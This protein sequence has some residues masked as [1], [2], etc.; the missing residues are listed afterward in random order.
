MESNYIKKVLSHLKNKATKR[1]LEAELAD[2][3]ALHKEQYAEIGYE[4]ARAFSLAEGKMG[5]ADVAGEQLA[6]LECEQKRRCRLLLGLAVLSLL[7]TVLIPIASGADSTLLISS[8]YFIC[9]LWNLIN[10][11]LGLRYK[12]YAN[13]LL[14]GGSALI[15]LCY[16][17]GFWG[18]WIVDFFTSRQQYKEFFGDFQPELPITEPVEYAMCVLAALLMLTGL[19]TTFCFRRGS[20]SK[21]NKTAGHIS[22]C[23]L[24]AFILLLSAIL[25]FNAVCIAAYPRR[26]QQE[27][28]AELQQFDKV[29]ADNLDDILQGDFTAVT[30]LESE[31]LDVVVRSA[32][33]SSKAFIL[34]SN[35]T[36]YITGKTIPYNTEEA[37]AVQLQQAQQKDF[38]LQDITIPY[39]YYIEVN[40]DG[41]ANIY[42][43]FEINDSD[44]AKTGDNESQRY[45]AFEWDDATLRV[46][47]INE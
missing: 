32:A 19:W 39:G 8:L 15:E 37:V 40:G 44:D 4:E 17:I 3:I 9:L 35:H 1:E 45:L 47:A 22:V 31:H 20:Y 14:G 38:A 46:K 43:N 6:A 24:S 13:I 33:E 12:K 36:R 42:T 34:V 28:R 25:V 10:L 21:Q 27:I 5:D 23:V 26:A 30:S 7:L 16:P 11:L 41:S 18:E 29:L 2:H